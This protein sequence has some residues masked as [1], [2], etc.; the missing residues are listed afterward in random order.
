MKQLIGF[1]SFIFLLAYQNVYAQTH[2]PAGDVS[3]T[4]AKAGSPYLIDGDIVILNSQ[5][6]TIEPGATVHFTGNYILEV[7]GALKA[8]G[9]ENDSIEFSVSDTTGYITKEHVG[10]RGISVSSNDLIND[11]IILEHCIV[12]FA[13]NAAGISIH[14][15]HKVRISNSRISHNSTSYGA[16]IYS[17]K[18]TAI[19]DAN[20][21]INN[22]AVGAGG[23]LFDNADGVIQGNRIMHNSGGGIFCGQGDVSISNNVI[24]WNEAMNDGG[25]ITLGEYNNIRIFNNVVSYNKSVNRGGGIHCSDSY[26]SDL[27]LVNN[28]VVGNESQNGAGGF[29]C[30]GLDAVVTNC[31]FWNNIGGE[32]NEP[33]SFSPN[34]KVQYCA[35]QGGY[36]G[37]GNVNLNSDNENYEG[38]GFVGPSSNDFSISNSSILVNSGATAAEHYYGNDSLSRIDICGVNRWL[39]GAPSIGA[40]ENEFDGL[41]FSISGTIYDLDGIS[42]L[43]GIWISGTYSDHNGEYKLNVGEGIDMTFAP[44]HS[45]LVFFPKNITD[46]SFDLEGVDFTAQGEYASC[47]ITEPTI[48]TKS[49]SPYFLN[50]NMVIHEY[51]KLTIEPGVEVLSTEH[52]AIT[53]LGQLIA[54]GTELDTI[55]FSVIDTTG[56]SV[57]NHKGWQGI[58][59]SNNALNP[60]P[61]FFDYCNIEYVNKV[62]AYGK[63]GAL[64]IIN[65]SSAR[66]NHCCFK[67]N[68]GTTGG[69]LNMYDQSDV[70]IENSVFHNNKAESGGAVYCSSNN[71]VFISDCEIANNMATDG[72]GLFLGGV[73][74]VTIRDTRIYENE[75]SRG[76]GVFSQNWGGLLLNNIIYENSASYGSGIYCYASNLTILNNTIVKNQT[77]YSGSIYLRYSPDA[78]ILN[79]VIWNSTDREIHLSSTSSPIIQY[80]AI[81]LGYEGVGNVSLS[82]MNEETDGPNFTDPT[83]NDFNLSQTSPLIDA[84]APNLFDYP[85]TIDTAPQWDISGASRWLGGIPDMGAYEY[86]GSPYPF[87]IEGTIYARDSVTPIPGVW[88]NGVVSDSE[89]EYTLKLRDLDSIVVA[90]FCD[91]AFFV[92]KTLEINNQSI[93]NF[94]FYAFGTVVTCDNEF[95]A[96]WERSKSPYFIRCNITIPDNQLLTIESGV[97]A[98]FE[99]QTGLSVR[100]SLI[101]RGNK[102]DSIRFSYANTSPFSVGKANN[103]QGIYAFHPTTNEDSVKLEYCIIED[104]YGGDDASVEIWGSNEFTISNSLI[105]KNLSQD[106]GIKCHMVDSAVIFNNTIIHNRGGNSGGLNIS[107]SNAKVMNNIIKNN[108]TNSFGGGLTIADCNPILINNL[109]ANNSVDGTGGSGIY[110]QTANAILIN[111]TIVNNQ[112]ESGGGIWCRLGSNPSIYNSVIWGNSVNQIYNEG[113]SPSFI[114]CGIEQGSNGENN[115]NLDSENLSVTGPNFRNPD[116]GNYSLWWNSPL[117]DAGY[118]DTILPLLHTEDL[119]GN[120]RIAN[121]Q[122][123]IGAFEFDNLYYINVEISG[124]GSVSPLDTTIF[125]DDTL[126]FIILPEDSFELSQVLYNQVE[127]TSELEQV[128]SAFFF[129]VY[130]I[131]SNS[132][133]FV[134]FEKILGVSEETIPTIAIYPNPVELHSSI[135]IRARFEENLY[136]EIYSLT[137]SKLFSTFL[138]ESIIFSPREF[139]NSQGMYIYKLMD[140]KLNTVQKGLLLVK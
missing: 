18:G 50:C 38:P 125:K 41:L 27:F 134:A 22:S 82:G 48:W 81:H 138:I 2:I 55:R 72:G 16:G 42:P 59:I 109:I 83:T 51:Q 122:I 112:S 99:Y 124:N 32:I 31:V 43:E 20:V 133:L 94:N 14:D 28:T 12:C 119:A 17:Y 3:G 29:S 39:D 45:S 76:G 115:I 128:D 86:D 130:G 40:Y 56:F 88:I 97:E 101:A 137:G 129:T 13:K 117:V 110:L 79:S 6:L 58:E 127:V 126:T 75:A 104:V 139:T 80:S 98:L 113:S 85:A 60:D 70:V 78:I 35:V 7:E 116:E 96:I 92:S 65:N 34:L 103:W 95:P 21:I 19:I 107:V 33:G 61:T 93:T 108:T 140:T 132:Y 67:R 25:G 111:N 30:Y 89:G 54:S 10:W 91:T 74:G 63:N 23:I 73:A 52:G 49:E 114:S 118:Q 71:S 135:E 5:T 15:S 106:G 4:W 37:Q 66:V 131:D 123:D 36:Q 102:E 100:G 11:S 24:S 136:L 9:L 62:N 64:S 84:G 68:T 47:E 57:M 120:P 53:V 8:I 105:T 46:I 1:L 90:P 121:D 69:A 44:Y 26:N 87:I 77:G